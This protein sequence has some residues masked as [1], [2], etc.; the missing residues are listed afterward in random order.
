MNRLGSIFQFVSNMETTVHSTT[1]TIQRLVTSSDIVQLCEWAPLCD[2]V[3]VPG[4]RIGQ[5]RATR[6]IEMFSFLNNHRTETNLDYVVAL[7]LSD[8]QRHD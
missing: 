8:A 3:Q 6:N 5:G 7:T 2:V 1:I 4:T